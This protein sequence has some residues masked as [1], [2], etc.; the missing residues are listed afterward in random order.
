MATTTCS[1][2]EERQEKPDDEVMDWDASESSFVPPYEMQAEIWEK[3]DDNVAS[4][5]EVGVQT[6]KD[7]NTDEMKDPRKEFHEDVFYECESEYA[8]DAETHVLEGEAFDELNVAD[9]SM[10]DT[11]QIALDSGAGEHVASR[12]TALKYPVV[13]SAGSR[14]GQHF[15]AAGGARIPN[16]GQFKLRLRS[17]GMAKGEGKDIESTFQ[18]AKVTRPLWSVGR[19]CDEGFSINFTQTEAVV[20]DKLGKAICKFH[21]KGGLYVADL[22]LKSPADRSQDFPRR[23][24]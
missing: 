15:V 22:Q 24:K 4:V 8:E 20:K 13:E 23:G 21:R 12:S 2:D 5:R 1:C 19:I 16:E 10:A 17:G 11:L 18:V 14:A 6:E 9:G 7:Y 3:I